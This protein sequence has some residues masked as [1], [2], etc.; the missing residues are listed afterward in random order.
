MGVI[1]YNIMGK[2]KYTLFEYFVRVNFVAARRLPKISGCTSPFVFRS[3]QHNGI[4]SETIVNYIN[5]VIAIS[6]E[7]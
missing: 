2:L 3:T 4:I 5:K 1:V 7:W 6:K